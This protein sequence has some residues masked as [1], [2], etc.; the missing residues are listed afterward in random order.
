MHKV[1]CILCLYAR[2]M[3]CWYFSRT[4]LKNTPSFC[5]GVDTAVE[6]KYR[7]EGAKLIVDTGTALGLYPIISMSLTVS[8]IERKHSWNRLVAYAMRGSVCLSVCQSRR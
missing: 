7:H 6:E 2:K 5:N 4:E 1:M 3:P 8:V